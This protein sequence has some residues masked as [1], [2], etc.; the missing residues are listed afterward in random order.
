MSI[1]LDIISSMIGAIFGVLITIAYN[2]I[3]QI[4]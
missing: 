4:K 2:A 3:K 1:Q